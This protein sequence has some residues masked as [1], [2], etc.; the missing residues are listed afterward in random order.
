MKRRMALVYLAT[1]FPVPFLGT[2][3]VFAQEV[4]TQFTVGTGN[5]VDD[6]NWSIAGDMTGNNPNILSELAWSDLQS[7]PMLNLDLKAL[8]HD[9]FYFRASYAGGSIQEGDNQDSDYLGDDRTLEF[10]R[11]NNKAD[12]GSVRDLS[13]G[14]GYQIKLG[15][16]R[17]RLTPMGGYSRHEQNLVMTNGY[18]T[19]DPY[20]VFGGTG[21][22]AGLNSTYDAEWKGT[23]GGVDFEHEVNKKFS[24]YG[25]ASYHVVDYDGVGNWN[26]RTDFAHPVSFTQKADGTGIVL[27]AGATYALADNVRLSGGV[28]SQSWSTDPGVDKVYFADGTT[29]TTR[30]N[31]V[32]WD[33]SAVYIGVE[34]FTKN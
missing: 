15:A 26:L 13:F 24:V 18:Q 34:F 33:S 19:L 20:G 4:E 6:L 12:G 16:G 31:E 17:T 1:V 22:F 27:A 2:P 10:S 11:S 14:V 7:Y 23:W 21:P 30:L 32:N 29:A 9:A 5:R 28:N 8:V 25:S 3:P